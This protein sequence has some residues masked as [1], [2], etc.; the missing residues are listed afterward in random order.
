MLTI[1]HKIHSECLVSSVKCRYSIS[2]YYTDQ[3]IVNNSCLK[4]VLSGEI[5]EYYYLYLY[6]DQWIR[7]YNVMMQPEQETKRVKLFGKILSVCRCMEKI[8]TIID[9]LYHLDLNQIDIKI[10]YNYYVEYKI[11]N[12]Y[13]LTIHINFLLVTFIFSSLIYSVI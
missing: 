13:K 1:Y 7:D 3:Y 6:R 9:I 2:T 12:H 4:M 11:P 8:I 5:G 10:T